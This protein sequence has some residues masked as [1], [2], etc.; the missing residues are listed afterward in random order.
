MRKLIGFIT[1]WLVLIPFCFP[2]FGAPVNRDLAVTVG[3]VFIQKEMGSGVAVEGERPTAFSPQQSQVAKVT[4]LKNDAG[5]TVAYVLE[6]VGDGYVVVSTDT[7]I[8]PVIAY[9]YSGRFPFE[10]AEQNILLYMVKA[11]M[12]LRL[13]AM[14]LMSAE[15][16]AVNQALWEEM[17]W[18]TA[19]FVATTWGPWVKTAWHQSSP[20]WNYCPKDGGSRA[21]V[22]CVATAMGQVI[23]YHRYPKSVSFGSGD[24]YNT[25]TR[26]IKVNPWNHN[27]YGYL[28]FNALNNLLKNVKYNGSA[29][30]VA[31]LSFASGISVEMDY[32]KNWSGAYVSDVAGAFR[33]KFKYKSAN[34]Y[35]GKASNF[36]TT[37]QANMKK[38]RPGVLGIFKP[39]YTAG[40]AIVIDGYRSSGEYH[41]N[42]GWGAGNNI[43]W[44]RL[45]S[46]MPSGYTIVHQ[47]TFDI[48]PGSVS[49]SLQVTY[50]NGGQ[51]LIKG[52]RY[53]IRWKKGNAGSW[54]RIYLYKNGKYYRRISNKTRNDGVYRW[55]VSKGY[56]TNSRYKIKIQSR[57]KASVYDYSDR[58]FTITT[59][60]SK[61]PKGTWTI[62]YKWS[63][64][65]KY[66]TATWYIYSNKTFRDSQG[67]GGTWTQSGSKVTLKYSS[68]C[69]PHY[70][71]TIR[72][73]GTYMSGTMRCTSGSGSGKWYARKKSSSLEP[74]EAEI[75]EPDAMEA[76]PSSP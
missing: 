65:P 47:G 59:K 43:G 52:K 44:Y 55:Y 33:N 18:N 5:K 10:D 54:V 75:L 67:N 36:Y 6:P 12:T 17:Q 11:D 32:T 40:H 35:S 16:K 39:G 31:A 20:Y 22:G 45:P 74:A 53:N 64:S 41:L 57:S 34:T 13:D 71:G 9:A 23:N 42:Y 29:S 3:E 48:V 7:R 73:S 68:G 60:S 66:Y 63:S 76:S 2:A 51:K 30:E 58:N 37:A 69:R 26:G 61:S 14:P 25:K 62:Y 4:P 24:S 21:V 70:K 46:G 50:P 56:K 8:T 1:L 28:S 72:T 38:R 27:T 19:P 15:K 49:S